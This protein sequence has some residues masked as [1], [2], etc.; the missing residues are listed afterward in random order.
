M[1]TLYKIPLCYEEGCYLLKD[2]SVS[3][4]VPDSE[5][6]ILK[7]KEDVD[8]ISNSINDIRTYQLEINIPDKTEIIYRSQW[9][10]RQQG[11]GNNLYS[12]CFI[13]SNN[14]KL[15][16][17]LDYNE[18]IYKLRK[19]KVIEKMQECI[20][21]CSTDLTNALKKVPT[22]LPPL[23][24]EYYFEGNDSSIGII[25]ATDEIYHLTLQLDTAYL[26]DCIIKSVPKYD[27]SIIFYSIIMSVYN[28]L[29]FEIPSKYSLSDNYQLFLPESYYLLLFK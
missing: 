20:E 11:K 8:I 14:T 13:Y 21:K 4:E 12:V 5:C 16:V 1:N 9:K 22:Q 15:P 6:L 26:L 25:D 2:I 7:H 29:C 17:F 24:I 3:D 23:V 27:T 18:K 19:N 10:Y 28:S